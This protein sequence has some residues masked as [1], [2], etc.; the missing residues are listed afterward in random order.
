M[1]FPGRAGATVPSTV[2]GAV[3][4]DCIPPAGTSA[5]PVSLVPVLPELVGAGSV[6]IGS[7]VLVQAL[8]LVTAQIA[9]SKLI[10]FMISPINKKN[11]L[12][13]A[14]FARAGPCAVQAA[15][16][17]DR[18]KNILNYSRNLNLFSITFTGPRL[19]QI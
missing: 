5:P 17:E 13:P 8:R 11:F 12:F 3:V 7:G 2:P 19:A 10:F 4:V 1:A 16:W 6:T 15:K 18:L 9:R 14:H